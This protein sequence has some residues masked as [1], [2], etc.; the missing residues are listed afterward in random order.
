MKPPFFSR[1][2]PAL[3]LYWSVLLTASYTF[4]RLS[5][6]VYEREYVFFDAPV[7]TWFHNIS[8][9]KLTA[10]ALMLTNLGSV[11]AL[12]VL[13][14]V[15]VFLVWRISKRSAAFGDAGF[16]A[17]ATLDVVAKALFARLRPALFTQLIPEH[18][19]SFPSGHTMASTAFF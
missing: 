11:Y 3:L 10:L 15:V 17:A 2:H 13:L 18:D 5:D 16:G 14:L 7:L 6:E 12:I 8:T 4:A 9:P 1:P 19:F